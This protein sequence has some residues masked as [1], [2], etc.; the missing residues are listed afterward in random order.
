MIKKVLDTDPTCCKVKP[1]RFSY[2]FA[3]SHNLSTQA[4]KGLWNLRFENI[5]NAG[6]TADATELTYNP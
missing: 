4:L 3:T 6:D 2:M 1:N 5:C